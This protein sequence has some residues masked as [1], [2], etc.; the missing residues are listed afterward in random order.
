MTAPKKNQRATFQLE[1]CK[2]FSRRARRPRRKKFLTA[3]KK[4]SARPFSLS[5]VKNFRGVLAGERSLKS[6]SRIKILKPV[7]KKPS[8][9]Y[10]LFGGDEENRTPVQKCRCSTF[11]ERS[12][13]KISASPNS[14]TNLIK[15]EHFEL[16]APYSALKR[17]I[18]VS[19]VDTDLTGKESVRRRGGC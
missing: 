10:F 12:R 15:P 5:G 1:R 6:E 2:K 17:S 7:G 13:R 14:T 16:P 4:I 19:D 8:G 3:T 9:C 18:P 11:S